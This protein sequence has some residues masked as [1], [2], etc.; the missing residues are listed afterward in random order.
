MESEPMS[1]FPALPIQ[2]LRLVIGKA[3]C[4][5]LEFAPEKQ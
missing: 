3:G 5:L 4:L 1:K 2:L